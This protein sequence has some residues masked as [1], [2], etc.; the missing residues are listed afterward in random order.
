MQHGRAYLNIVPLKV[1]V[2]KLQF[3]LYYTLRRDIF[4]LFYFF[5]L[6]RIARWNYKKI[7]FCRQMKHLRCTFFLPGFKCWVLFIIVCCASITFL[8]RLYCL[9]LFPMAI[10][11]Y[12]FSFSSHT[13]GPVRFAPLHMWWLWL[14]RQNNLRPFKYDRV[15]N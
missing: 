13:L 4:P 9:L 3:Y 10:T 2:K 14:P 6:Y 7:P 1:F 11:K 15:L 5:F 12:L 8:K